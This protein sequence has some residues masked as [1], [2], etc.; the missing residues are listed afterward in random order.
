MSFSLLGLLNA[1]SPK[2]RQSRR[3]ASGLRY[4]PGSR[5]CLDLFAPRDASGPLPVIVF[6]Y[7]GSW[8]EG[9]RRDYRFVGRALAALGYLVAV[10]DYRLVPEIE[11][12]RFLEDCAAAVHLVRD[13]AAEHGGDANRLALM[14]HSAGAYN[15][16]MLGLHP[17]Y[18]LAGRLSAVVGLS[19]PYD[20]YPFDVD[21]TRR[22]FGQVAAPET[23]QPV[24]LVTP[25]AP[26]MF[27]ATG[28]RDTLVYPRNTV[29]LSARL[30]EN[31]V[32]VTERHY[33]KLDHAGTLLE[34]GSLLSGRDTVFS[35][36]AAF[37]RQR[38]APPNSAEI[39]LA[40]AGN[41]GD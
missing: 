24:N 32:A 31:G 15:A 7:G 23:T 20:F 6:I 3:I 11:Y 25:S 14:G 29:A 37:L 19:G 21:V 5:Q 26:P 17:G 8:N 41:D 1:I 16:V 33:A 10:P 39:A 40:A 34:L 2:T 4:G 36:V 30:R 9:D 12:P 22:T 38:L 13:V 35:D 27:L 28:E 18:D